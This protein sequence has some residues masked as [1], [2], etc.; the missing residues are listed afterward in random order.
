[1][2]VTGLGLLLAIP[3]A[4]VC[5]LIALFRSDDW[6]PYAAAGA[7][8]SILLIIPF[9]YLLATLLF[10]RSPFPKLV[11]ASVYALV[12]TLWITCVIIKALGLTLFLADIVVL[13]NYQL[14]P[15]VFLVVLYGAVLPINVLT[16]RSSVGALRRRVGANQ[17]AGDLPTTLSQDEIYLNPFGGVIGWSLI[18]VLMTVLSGLLG[19]LGT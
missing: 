4:L 6:R 19:F 7:K 14:G 5:V 3:A 13:H 15:T 8:H 2:F 10:H 11:L 17:I 12:Y 18:T 16:L 1:M 9:I